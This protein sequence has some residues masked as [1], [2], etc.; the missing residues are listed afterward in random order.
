[1]TNLVSR[2]MLRRLHKI[3]FTAAIAVVLGGSL[4]SLNHPRVSAQAT[5]PAIAPCPGAPA[6]HLIIGELARV[7]PGTPDNVRSAP[8]KTADVVTQIAENDEVFV[9]GAPTCADGYLW[10]PIHTLSGF[11]GWAAEG[12]TQTAFLNPTTGAILSYKVAGGTTPVKITYNGFQLSYAPDLAAVLGKTI[13][14]TTVLAFTDDPANPTPPGSNP[15]YDR[16]GFGARTVDNLYTWPTLSI[17]PVAQ[18]EALKDDSSKAAI[19]AAIAFLKNKV[20]PT[21][22]DQIPVYPLEMQGQVLHAQHRVVD[23]TGGVGF[24]FVTAYASDVGPIT[25]DRGLHYQFIGVTNDGKYFLSFSVPITTAALNG[26]DASFPDMNA[27][28][29]ATQYPKYVNDTAAK[30]DKAATTDFSIDL[31]QLDTLMASITAG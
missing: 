23:F 17:Y 6:P 7:T 31:E 1:M 16:W 28:D 25:N 8:S 27:P 9:S 26:N 15:A 12:S 19:D 14:T 24:R 21:T 30:L 3:L 29:I 22:V 4:V 11:D 18:V 20:D 10:W 13:S 5:A 2:Q